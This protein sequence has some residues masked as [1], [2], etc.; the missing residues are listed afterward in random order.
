M[1]ANTADS[2]DRPSDSTSGA[3]RIVVFDVPDDLEALA[4]ALMA[5]PDMDRPTAR[6]QTRV[7]PGVITHAFSREIADRVVE[8][9]QQLGASAAAVPA[10]ELPDLLHAHPTHHVRLTDEMLEAIDTS[11]KQHSYSWSAISLISVG[12]L[13]SALPPRFRAPAALSGGS[14]HRSWNEGVRIAAKRRPEAFVVLSEDQQ[15]LNLPSDGMNYEYLADRLSTS[16][17]TNFRLLIKDLVSRASNAWVTP[18]TLAFLEHHPGPKT[19][20][21]SADDFRRYTEFQAALGRR[22]KKQT[23]SDPPQ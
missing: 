11:D 10:T 2:A 23:A 21:K 3:F 14:S 9:I 20:F 17:G 22:H 18:S 7:L 4:L 13:P 16:S 5:L 12:I 15:T 8:V 1:S 6:L 19:E